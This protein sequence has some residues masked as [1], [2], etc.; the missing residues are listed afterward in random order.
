MNFS[1]EAYFDVVLDRVHL[2]VV[3]SRLRSQLLP[4][5]Y[6]F[7]SHRPLVNPNLARQRLW[8]SFPHIYNGVIIG[9]DPELVGAL[10][11]VR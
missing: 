8:C 1:N 2:A 6:T 11:P 7:D 10:I 3:D 9:F 5:I 4:T